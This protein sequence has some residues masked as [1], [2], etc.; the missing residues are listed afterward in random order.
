MKIHI[1]YISFPF[2][3]ARS[4]HKAAGTQPLPLANTMGRRGYPLETSNANEVEKYSS[5]LGSLVSHDPERS[6]SEPP[7]VTEA[8]SEH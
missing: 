2:R 7:I 3:A 8:H 6:V 4:F 1:V 5:H